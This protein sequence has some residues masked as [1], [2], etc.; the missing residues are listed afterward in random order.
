[1]FEIGP[2]EAVTLRDFTNIY[3][4]DANAIETNITEGTE[5]YNLTLPS[6]RDE[7]GFPALDYLFHGSAPSEGEILARF[8]NEE[9]LRVYLDDV[10]NRMNALASE[11][12]SEWKNNYRDTFVER[13]GSDASSSVN[14]FL[15]DYL[16]YYEKILRAG[17]IGIPA[18]VF[19]NNPLPEKVEAFYNQEV[20]KVLHLT[21]LN[22]TIDF[23]NGNHF[24]GNGSGESLKSYLDFLNT[25]TEGEQLSN[26]I[27]NQ[28]DQAIIESEKLNDNFYQQVSDNNTL[29]LQAFDAIQANVVL[30]KVDMFQALNVK[31][32]FVDA[33]GD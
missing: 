32:D 26:L 10:V 6:A 8:S 22:A 7:Q 1:M 33:D 15:N 29:M 13:S 18:G 19:S 20:S 30:L 5:L 21:A 17:K 31:V 24:D 3:P 16:F 23:F 28:F 14:K 25:I 12:L 4:A 9:N 11:V 2:A 27:N